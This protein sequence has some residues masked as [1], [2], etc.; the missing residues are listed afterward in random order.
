M[1]IDKNDTLYINNPNFEIQC[2]LLL[3][4]DLLKYTL[5]GHTDYVCEINEIKENNLISCGWREII[6]WNLI[7]G[8]KLNVF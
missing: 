8:D 3:N 2:F 7:N 1:Y 5:K 6:I 4:P